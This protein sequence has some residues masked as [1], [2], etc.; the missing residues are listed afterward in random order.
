MRKP[1]RKIRLTCSCGKTYEALLYNVKS[2]HTKSCGC[3]RF[4]VA[5]QNFTKHGQARRG[6]R[7]SEYTIWKGMR[8]RCFDP[9]N[10][11]FKY[12]GARGISLCLRWNKFENFFEDMGPRPA[13]NYSIERI[14][15]EGDYEPSNCKWIPRSEQSKNRRGVKQWKQ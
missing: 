9:G 15:N 14:N 5:Q 13:S 1:R 10:P 3:R 11:G 12:Y 7:T 6:H 2:G 4:I 8:Q